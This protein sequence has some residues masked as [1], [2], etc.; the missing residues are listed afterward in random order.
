[1]QRDV[2]WAQPN[3]IRSISLKNKQHRTQAY[4]SQVRPTKT[5]LSHPSRTTTSVVAWQARHQ[6]VP[7]PRPPTDRDQ[8]LTWRAGSRR[9]VAYCRI[10]VATPGFARPGTSGVQRGHRGHRVWKV[11]MRSGQSSWCTH[12]TL[13]IPS[14]CGQGW[15]P[16]SRGY[17]G[18]SGD[19]SGASVFHSSKSMHACPHILCF[20]YV[21]KGSPP[22]YLEVTF[23]QL[24][25]GELGGTGVEPTTPIS[26]GL[27][28]GLQNVEGYDAYGCPLKHH[29]GRWARAHAP[30]ARRCTMG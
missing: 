17:P 25:R 7:R 16:S 12:T 13:A 27:W 14:R 6:L 11:R 19:I 23:F 1:M 3:S 21:A 4:L 28:M 2:W 5:T 10:R 22:L 18:L 20:S 8:G 29:Y 15:R 24:N 9:A 26:S 30:G